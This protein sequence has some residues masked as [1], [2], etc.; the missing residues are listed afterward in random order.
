MTDF[1]MIVYMYNSKYHITVN[2]EGR[3]IPKK[4]KLI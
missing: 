1:G 3:K 2:W 4:K